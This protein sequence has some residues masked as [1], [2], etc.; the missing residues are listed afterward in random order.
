MPTRLDDELLN[1]DE[2]GWRLGG[3]ASAALHRY[4][5]PPRQGLLSWWST[6]TLLEL[7]TTSA[8]APVVAPHLPGISYLRLLLRHLLTKAA[9]LILRGLMTAG[10]HRND[11]R[12]NA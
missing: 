1:F 11:N 12:Q 3:Y 6:V 5:L 2:E 4:V 9:D 10:S 8:R 7:R